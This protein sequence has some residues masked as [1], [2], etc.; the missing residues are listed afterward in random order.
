MTVPDERLRS[1]FGSAAAAYAEHRPD[2][3]RDAVLRALGGEPG[4]RVLDLGAGT[5]KLTRVLV[6]RADWVSRFAHAC[7][8]AV[9]G[10]RDTLSAWPAATATSYLPGRT[11]L[12]SVPRSGSTSTTRSG[13]PSTPSWLRSRPGP[14]C[15]S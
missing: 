9:V 11:L 7:G 5:G 4:V 14:A 2:Y 15:S 3:A 1:S 6:D 10:P 13:T 8:S 12:C